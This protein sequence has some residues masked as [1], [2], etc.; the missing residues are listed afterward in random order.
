MT[1]LTVQELRYMAGISVVAHIS[2]GLVHGFIPYEKGFI[3]DSDRLY[4]EQD[5]VEQKMYAL[6]LQ[7][8]AKQ[9]PALDLIR[10]TDN[11]VCY[12]V[13]VSNRA[14]GW[15]YLGVSFFD[16]HIYIGQPAV[17]KETR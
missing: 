5:D 15:L 10:T 14:G 2:I 6:V 8:Y 13:R 17:W 7:A 11:K 9:L 1:A 12:T 16:N 4:F 3:P